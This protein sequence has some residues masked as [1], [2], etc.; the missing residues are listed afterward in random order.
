LIGFI[1]LNLSKYKKYWYKFNKL[2]WNIYYFTDI[3][4][5]QYIIIFLII[6]NNFKKIKNF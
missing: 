3:Y 1:S 5:N 4:F 6:I 2:F